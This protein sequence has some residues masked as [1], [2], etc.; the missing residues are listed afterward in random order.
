MFAGIGGFRTGLAHAGD[1]F[2]LWV[3]VRSIPSVKKPTEPYTEQE[4][5]ISI[6][7]QPESTPMNSPRSISSAADF[8]A[9]HSPSA[10]SDG[11]LTTQE[12]RSFMKSC[13]WLKPG[14]LN[15]FCLKTCRGFSTT[16]AGRPSAL[17]SER[18]MSWG[19]VSNGACLTA[20][21]SESRIK[22]DGCILSDILIKDC[23]A[24]STLLLVIGLFSAV[25]LFSFFTASKVCFSNGLEETFLLVIGQFTA[26]E[27]C[28]VGGK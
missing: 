24:I 3:G 20:R 10:E 19:I 27:K 16:T 1:L 22:G 7:T 12:V 4:V 13:A 6:V 2:C 5:N 15:I 28:F 18:Y 26:G 8:L 17:S 23:P 21:I 25:F 11:D 14:C 9:N